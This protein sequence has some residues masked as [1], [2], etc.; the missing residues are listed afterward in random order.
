MSA[1]PRQQMGN[2]QCITA[3]HLPLQNAL[4]ERAGKEVRTTEKKAHQRPV[5]SRLPLCFCFY[6]PVL[7]VTCNR[8]AVWRKLKNGWV[9]P[10]ALKGLATHAG[11]FMG[12]M[13]QNFEKMVKA[14]KGDK[15]KY[16]HIYIGTIL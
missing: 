4:L 13:I 7:Q 10:Q 5:V 11:S 12:G 6:S 8:Q 14:T 2:G 9:P 3:P 16:I 1:P 15:C